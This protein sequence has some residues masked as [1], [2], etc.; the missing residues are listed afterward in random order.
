MT[1]LLLGCGNSRIKKVSVPGT[2]KDW[3]DLITLDMDPR[4]KADVQFN[5]DRLWS[6]VDQQDLPFAGNTFDEVHAY[7]VLEHIGE[8][9]NLVSFFRP[10]A[11][12]YRVLKP[13][14]LLVGTCPV[15]DSAWAWGDPGHRRIIGSEQMVFLDQLEYVKQ[16]GITPMT[17]YR[18]MW[19]GDFEALAFQ[20]QAENLV[21]VLRAH[22]PARA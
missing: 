2:P 10:F 14:G 20:K 22:K 11:E 17:D 4:C 6:G 13:G 19:R 16:V 8:Q 5:L 18:S 1:E 9:G 7:E 21:F 12:I 15:W 3:T